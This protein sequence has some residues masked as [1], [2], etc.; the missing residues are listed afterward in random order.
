M[1]TE[2]KLVGGGAIVIESDHSAQA[3]LMINMLNTLALRGVELVCLKDSI[4]SH[5][6]I[7]GGLVCVRKGQMF[8]VD[9]ALLAE[10][11]PPIR[12]ELTRRY[13]DEPLLTYYSIKEDNRG[14]N[15]A[16][17]RSLRMANQGSK[18]KSKK[19]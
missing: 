12:F 11:I 6:N 15:E 8:S 9:E 2:V 16:W 14:R 19:R 13:Q 10:A 1:K 17:K 4:D 18:I 5:G 7:I 3:I